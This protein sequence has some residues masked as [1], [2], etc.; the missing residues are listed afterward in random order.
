MIFLLSLILI[1]II[2][3]A[4]HFFAAKLSKCKVEIFAIGFGKSIF[5]KKIG[6]TIYQFN[7]ILFGGFCKLKDELNY[8]R[9][10]YAFTNKTYTQKVFI[11]L[12]GI[13]LNVITGILAIIIGKL[14][15]NY[16][17]YI[18]GFYSIIVGLS[19]LIPV[20]ALDGSYPI[21]FLL[22]YKLGKK[23][24]YKLMTSLFSKFMKWIMILNLLSVP[25]LIYWLF[26]GQIS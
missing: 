1:I 18:F 26:T 10:K 20:P 16:Y 13:G 12:A 7:W 19:N 24:T 5:E 2:H 17:L 4:G 22:E 23:R 8:S 14:F 15:F 11:A 6:E 9:S 25:F 3:E 21:F